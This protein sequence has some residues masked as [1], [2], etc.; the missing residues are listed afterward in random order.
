[1]IAQTGAGLRCADTDRQAHGL[2][3]VRVD[4]D[5]RA[6]TACRTR[7]ATRSPSTRCPATATGEFIAAE[8]GAGVADAH[9]RIDTLRDFTQ[10]RIPGEMPVPV[11]HPLEVIDVDHETHD[12]PAGALGARHLLAQPGLQIAPIVEA[13][14]KVREPLLS[15]RARLTV[16]S[17]H[18][19]VTST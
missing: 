16:F 3:D 14:E 2:G 11:V 17:R 19:A 12:G 10:H 4:F 7:A 18:S 15:R 8:A 13:R 9:L 6:R 5:R 1:M